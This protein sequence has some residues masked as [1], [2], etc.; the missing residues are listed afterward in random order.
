MGRH[1]LGA[2]DPE[3]LVFLC[4]RGKLSHVDMGVKLFARGKGEQAADRSR[5][6]AALVRCNF[7]Q[8]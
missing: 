1:Q 8:S 7:L 3:T 6:R 5:Q 4:L 2:P